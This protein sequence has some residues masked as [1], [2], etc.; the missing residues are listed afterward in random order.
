MEANRTHHGYCLTAAID[1]FPD[2]EWTPLID[3]LV[4]AREDPRKAQSCSAARKSK[5]K[6]RRSAALHAGV[7]SS[8][9]NLD[10]G[11][12]PKAPIPIPNGGASGP[13]ACRRHV[14]GS[15]RN[16]NG[17]WLIVARAAR[18]RRSK[19][20]TNCQAT[21]NAGCYLTTPCNRSP[22][23]KRQKKTACDQ[24]TNQKLSHFG[25]LRMSHHRYN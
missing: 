2:V 7:C 20:C 22:G 3:Q 17:R 11:P 5:Q 24:Q 18:Y 14:D 13:I 4:G 6:P 23:C 8:V 19:Q 16:V 21:N 9:A 15:G 1:P 25:P 12:I 10:A